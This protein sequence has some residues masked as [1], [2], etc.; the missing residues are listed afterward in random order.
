MRKRK[1]KGKTPPPRLSRFRPKPPLTL[2]RARTPPFRGPSPRT[3]APL[4]SATAS[5]A[6]PVSRTPLA[7]SRSLSLSGKRVPLVSAFLAPVT[8][9]ATRSPPATACPV[10]SPLSRSPARFGALRLPEPSHRPVCPSHPVATTV[11]HHVCRCS[12]PLAPFPAPGAYKRTARAPSFPTPA[13]A[14]PSS[15]PRAR[16]SQHRRALPPLR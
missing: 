3:R 13:S 8:G 14:T 5:S 12:P 1:R 10:A 4:P 2:P 11:R 16:L 7:L 15:L 6:P 9:L